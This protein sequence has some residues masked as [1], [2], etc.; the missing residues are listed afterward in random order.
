L[1]R[2]NKQATP[3]KEWAYLNFVQSYLK[4][5]PKCTHQDI[6]RG[7]EK[8]RLAQKKIANAILDKVL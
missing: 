5:H 1:A 7:W 2:K 3:N 8:E 6:S 4:K